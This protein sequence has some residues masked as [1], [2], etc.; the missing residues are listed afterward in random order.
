MTLTAANAGKAHQ[1]AQATEAW[2][3]QAREPALEPERLIIDP[4]HHLWERATQRYLVEDYLHD[5]SDGHRLVGTV[6][7]ECWSGYRSEGPEHLRCVGETE[8]MAR[9]AKSAPSSIALMAGIVAHTD[10]MNSATLDA[11]LDAHEAAGEGRLRGIRHAVS[12]EPTGVVPAV[13][14]SPPGMLLESAFQGSVRR[15]GERGLSFDAWIYHTQLLELAALARSA[16]ETAIIL[17]H[18]GGPI[19]IGDYAVNRQETFGLWKEGMMALATCPNVSV[20]LSG[21]GMTLCGHGFKDRARPPSSQELAAAYGPHLLS[22]IELFGAD[23]CMFASNFPVDRISGPFGTL[24]NGYKRL[25]AAASETEKDAL[26]RAT[27]ARVYRL[28]LP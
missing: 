5:L 18:V 4:H 6:F 14:P 24:F 13:R 23:R 3:S 22:T 21:L 27:A 10:L 26:F 15:L 11:V 25:V 17:N 28:T 16:P 19:G 8:L 2:L 7:V 20:K 9:L 1:P 12:F